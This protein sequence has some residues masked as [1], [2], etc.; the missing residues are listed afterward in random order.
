MAQFEEHC[1]DNDAK[2]PYCGD[3]YQV[4]AEDY[5]EHAQE[6]ECYTCG[7]KYWLETTFSVTHTSTPDCALNGQEHKYEQSANGSFYKCI[8]CGK[9]TLQIPQQEDGEQ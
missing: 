3:A 6:I 7:K 9:I 8:V 5:A 4:E 1:D 2:C